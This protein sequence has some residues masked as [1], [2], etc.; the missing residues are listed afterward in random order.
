MSDK[1][2]VGNRQFKLNHIGNEWWLESLAGEPF[3]PRRPAE[4]RPGTS[5][6]ET[7]S[8]L[9]SKL[10]LV[11]DPRPT[12]EAEPPPHNENA[13][14]NGKG[15]GYY[16]YHGEPT[17]DK[18]YNNL[19]ND[20][21]CVV[22]IVHG[23]GRFIK[24][25]EGFRAQYL[26]LVKVYARDNAT[27]DNLAKRYEFE[28]GEFTLED[29]TRWKLDENL[30]E[31]LS[32]RLEGTLESRL[33]SLLQNNLARKQFQSQYQLS[34][35]ASPF[36]PAK[37]SYENVEMG[38]MGIGREVHVIADDMLVTTNCGKAI[39]GKRSPFDENKVTCFNCKV[40]L[41]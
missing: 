16:A 7:Y 39:N 3:D 5:C 38:F 22:A 8:K 34:Q 23:E 10:E 33:F 13:S 20:A 30:K 24:H 26:K 17:D 21:S 31:E 25:E 36:Q 29:D 28:R 41:K 6:H 14:W 9:I 2:L 32:S 37:I 19:M 15:C 27:L 12:L 1:T 4:C 18:V 35:Y 11:P 40:S